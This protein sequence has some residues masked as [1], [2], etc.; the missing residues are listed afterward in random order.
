MGDVLVVVL[1]CWIAGGH[2]A[3]TGVHTRWFAATC[4]PVPVMHDIQIIARLHQS[5]LMIDENQGFASMLVV[6]STHKAFTST[7][8]LMLANNACGQRSLS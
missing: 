3:G 6:H 5:A 8:L 7:A 2:A 1:C 4:L